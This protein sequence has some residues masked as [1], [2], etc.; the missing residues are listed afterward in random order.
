MFCRI[1]ACCYL[2]AAICSHL[3]PWTLAS[4]P[5]LGNHQCDCS[6]TH[7]CTKAAV[8]EK[9]LVVLLLL[10]FVWLIFCFVVFFFQQIWLLTL[11]EGRSHNLSVGSNLQF[12]STHYWEMLTCKF[13]RRSH[14]LWRTTPAGYKYS[15][16]LCCLWYWS[17]F[18]A[19]QQGKQCTCWGTGRPN[20]SY[21][22][23]YTHL[24]ENYLDQ[25]YSER[26][27]S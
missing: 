6:D 23:N 3:L 12:P 16:S 9:A 21:L 7:S 27:F 13:C 2:P 15:R 24:H 14:N 18:S 5:N 4:L 20:I 26:L 22:Q 19:Y 8:K 10:G 1:E 17:S 11:V 25:D